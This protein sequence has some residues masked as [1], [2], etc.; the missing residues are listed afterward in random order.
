MGLDVELSQ[1]AQR[2]RMGGQARDQPITCRD[3]GL[4]EW[5]PEQPLQQPLIEGPQVK[6][7]PTED[8]SGFFIWGPGGAGGGIAMPTEGLA[9]IL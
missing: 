6:T 8:Q 9:R 5:G 2:S 3:A 1:E 4:P 7:I